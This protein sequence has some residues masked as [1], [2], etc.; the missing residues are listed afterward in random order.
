MQVFVDRTGARRVA[1]RLVSWTVACGLLVFVAAVGG[2]L[3]GAW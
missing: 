3:L 1:A 2:T